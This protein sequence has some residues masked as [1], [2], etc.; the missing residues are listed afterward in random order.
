M[1]KSLEIAF[2][3]FDSPTM[4]NLT[5]PVLM[6]FTI[7]QFKVEKTLE[8]NNILAGIVASFR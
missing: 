5:N 8:D 3:L 4:G 7:S 6:G 2:V 1:G